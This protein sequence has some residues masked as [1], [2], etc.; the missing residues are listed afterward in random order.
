MPA[1]DWRRR[2]ATGGGGVLFD[3]G[4]H[5]MATVNELGGPVRTLYALTR[6]P[7]GAWEVDETAVVTC[8]HESGLVTNLIQSWNVRS[9]P[10]SPLMAVYGSEGSIV[11]VPEKRLPGHAP[12]EIGGLCV[13]SA[14][15]RE[16]QAPANAALLEGAELYMKTVLNASVP[17]DVLERILARGTLLD[18]AEE[19]YGYNVYGA[20][21]ADFREC[22]RTGK[23]PHV[24]P[25][26]ARA[27]I[28]LVFASYESARSGRP[29][30]LPPGEG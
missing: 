9:A 19:F 21:I 29:V 30:S 7:A 27:D 25:R 5:L 13:Y 18:I 17:A 6:C 26:D 23:R 2:E 16:F 4:V 1:Y 20:A 15:N 11:E 24:E 3:R 12:F 8:V 22:I 28:E 14:K 10:P